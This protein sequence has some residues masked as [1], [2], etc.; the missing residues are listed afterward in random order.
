M[1]SQVQSERR[2]DRLKRPPTVAE[3]MAQAEHFADLAE[4]DDSPGGASHDGAPIRAMRAA[5]K[6]RAGAD[7]EMV[8]AVE[9]AR[10]EGCSWSFIGSMIGTSGQA[11]REK[12]GIS[13]SR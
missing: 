8:V 9:S 1:G 4:S 6:K 3:I 13:T 7:A 11:A 2:H 5:F 10:A 12:Y